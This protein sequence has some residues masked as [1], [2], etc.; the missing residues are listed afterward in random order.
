MNLYVKKISIV[1]LLISTLGI[2]VNEKITGETI[3]LS[4]GEYPPY[5]SESLLYKG[6]VPRI[7][8]EAFRL[9]GVTVEYI[10]YPWKRAYIMSANGELDGTIQWLYSSDR[11]ADHYYS[12]A[13]MEERFVWFHLDSE[14]FSWVDLNDLEGLIIGAVSGYTYTEEFYNAVDENRIQVDF[15]ST[16]LQN[17][18]KL[19]YKR[20]QV[21]LENIDIGNH[22]L[23]T[24]FSAQTINSIT[25]HET[26][27]ISDNSYLLLS[28]INPESRRLLELFNDGLKKLKE[29]GHYE[30]YIQE[31]R[32]GNYIQPEVK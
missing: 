17:I 5:N 2:T 11:E 14:P 3:I 20:I 6:L 8:T 19:Q 32:Q 13:I 4:T 12:D 28:R 30:K 18:S 15:A 25:Y 21:F 10:F 1:I 26:P 27:F 22:L 23:N 16:S 29:N 9:A 7:V 24:H 31:S